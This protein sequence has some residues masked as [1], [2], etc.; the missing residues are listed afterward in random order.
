MKEN[1][2]PNFR[3]VRVEVPSESLGFTNLVNLNSLSMRL[4]NILTKDM[5][6]IRR[7][8]KDLSQVGM[9]SSIPIEQ[10]IQG[11]VSSLKM[12]VTRTE[13]RMENNGTSIKNSM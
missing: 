3:S 6:E 1:Q 11:I 4:K 9:D 10:A 7:H 5:L 2:N 8:E 12:E 13:A